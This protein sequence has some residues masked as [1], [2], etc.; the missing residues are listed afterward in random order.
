MSLL[1]V[2]NVLIVVFT[3]CLVLRFFFPLRGPGQP[4]GRKSPKNGEKLQKNSLPGPIPEIRE[5][6]QKNYKNCIFGVILPLF[7][8]NFSPFLGVGP[9]RGILKFFP[10]FGGF[11]PRRLSGGKTTGKFRQ[12]LPHNLLCVLLHDLLN[13]PLC[14]LLHDI[15]VF[16][17]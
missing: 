5:K 6:L 13:A 2:C 10:I 8:G 3:L 1:L 15:F 9:G 17:I 12:H 11:P 14:C 7:W 4:P 16:I